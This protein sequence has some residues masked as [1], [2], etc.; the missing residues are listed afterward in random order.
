M[1][2]HPKQPNK[3]T[4]THTR[5]TKHRHKQTNN[6]THKETNKHETYIFEGLKSTP[7][8]SKN[9]ANTM[10]GCSKSHFSHIRKEVENMTLPS[11]DTA[12]DTDT[13]T[14]NKTDTNTDTDTDT[15]NDTDMDTDTDN[16]Q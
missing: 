13:D 15:D 2:T 4:P 3:Q 16:Q 11:T 6:Q 7:S 8:K 10:E 1:H 12:T 9:I 5:T 14:D